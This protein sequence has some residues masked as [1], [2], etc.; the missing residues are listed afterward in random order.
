[1][2]L[3]YGGTGNNSLLTLLASLP[4]NMPKDFYKKRGE[5]INKAKSP[6]V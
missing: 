1:M 2:T 4:R 6:W 3:K 5:K